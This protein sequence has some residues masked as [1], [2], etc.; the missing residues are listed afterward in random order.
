MKKTVLGI[1][2]DQETM[3]F[4][5][6]GDGG[7]L[8]AAMALLTARLADEMGVSYTDLLSDMLMA[9]KMVEKCKPAL[10]RVTKI[11]LSALL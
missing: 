9:V 3:R 6:I 5:L 7:E 1:K 10:K 11:D 2:M 4:L 8:T